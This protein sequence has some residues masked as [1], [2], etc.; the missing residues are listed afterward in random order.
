[1]RSQH[2]TPGQK[3]SWRPPH[4]R[5]DNRTCVLRL[6]I[7]KPLLV[8]LAATSQTRQ[9]LG[10]GGQIRALPSPD[11]GKVDLGKVGDA[12]LVFFLADFDI[13]QLRVIRI[14]GRQE[15]HST[16]QITMIP[17]PLGQFNY[18]VGLVRARY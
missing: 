4:D 17:D 2:K 18:L 13:W 9:L 16:D 15:G 5:Q 7:T 3:R 1:S 6:G 14:K 8:H 10:G 12:T 11:F